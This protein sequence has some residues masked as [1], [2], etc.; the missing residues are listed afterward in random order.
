[1]SLATARVCR[2]Q[3]IDRRSIRE[4]SGREPPYPGAD[5]IL[6]DIR[7]RLTRNDA[8]L[9]L[10]LLSGG[11]ANAYAAAERRLADG[12]IEPLLDEP[13]LLRA[14]LHA[15]QGQCASLA[16]FTYVLVRHALLH[17]G[18]RS[19]A[20]ADYV[21][22]ILLHFGQRDRARRISDTDDEIVTTFAEL[23]EVAE[24]AHPQRAFLARA[25]LGN[26]ALWLSGLFPDHLESRRWRRGAPGLDYVEAMGARGF[27]M[28]ADHRLAAEHGLG[29]LF[30]AA[31]ERFP[32]IRRALNEVSDRLLFP[33]QHTPERLMRQVRSSFE[34]Q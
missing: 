26:Y 32:V 30:G 2:W 33:N 8:Q 12:G 24:R 5:V 1:V 29:P 14:L 15:R 28:A 20:M 25:H 13:P 21:A 11:S 19:R 6:A 18:E 22:S 7:V 17:G 34:L 23:L 10:R 9:V 4:Q 16:L 27:R 3:L 31:A